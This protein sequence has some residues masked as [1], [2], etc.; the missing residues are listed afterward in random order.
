M[1]QILNGRVGFKLIRDYAPGRECFPL[2]AVN[3]KNTLWG[4]LARTTDVPGP[5]SPNWMNMLSL[6][7]ALAP[8][9]GLAFD[10]DGLMFVSPEVFSESLLDALT[11]RLQVKSWLL[12]RLEAVTDFYVN[13]ATGN[14]DIAVNDGLTPETAWRTIQG[15]ID[16]IAN[17]YFMAL[18]ARLNVAAGTY[19]EDVVVPAYQR[20]KGTLV[21]VGASPSTT[22]VTGSFLFNA[23]GNYS[24]SNVM[25]RFA[26]RVSPGLPSMWMG[27]SVGI[28]V[29]LQSSNIVLD[30]TTRADIPGRY[31]FSTGGGLNQIREGCSC[32]NNFSSCLNSN[33]SG[34]IMLLGDMAFNGN[35]SGG[36]ARA[37]QLGLISFN[38]DAL[39]RNPIMS[40]NITGPRASLRLLSILDTGGSGGMSAFPGSSAGSKDASSQEF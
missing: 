36:T 33:S 1:P 20:S 14:D 37:S 31:G 15:G 23:A 8:G 32:I 21:I 16:N 6:L 27:V 40:G 12:K 28:G 24:L 19:D 13:G 30:G 29:N 5:A 38:P 22:I 35:V 9:G 4:C 17:T 7:G 3:Y 11:G 39:G 10:K 25:V 34:H 18:T 2:D 26:G